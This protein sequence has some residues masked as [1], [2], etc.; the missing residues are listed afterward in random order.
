M[1]KTTLAA[2][3]AFSFLVHNAA[4]ADVA[5]P[6]PPVPPPAAKA[7]T[8][9]KH[10]IVMSPGRIVAWVENGKWIDEKKIPQTYKGKPVPSDCESKTRKIEMGGV[11]GSETYRLFSGQADLGTGKGSRVSYTCDGAANEYYEIDIKPIDKQGKT[12]RWAINGDWNALPRLAKAVNRAGKRTWQVDLDGDGS[13]ETIKATS[14]PPKDKDSDTTEVLT[15]TLQ[16]KGKSIP[17]STVELGGDYSPSSA[18]LS[19]A[20]LNGDG[21]L[22]I[23]LEASGASAFLSIFDVSSGK[24]QS[25][26][27]YSESRD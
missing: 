17:L 10:P 12:W 26:G 2:C 14:K 27:G 21:V 7:R 8:N 20:D 5:P 4:S 24:P 6:P 19:F 13:E 23:V 1:K 22:D 15:F 18:D 9:T 11:T 16:M 3:C 25:V